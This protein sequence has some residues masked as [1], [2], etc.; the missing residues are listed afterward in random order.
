MGCLGTNH[1]RLLWIGF[2]V[3]VEV[4]GGTVDDE[5]DDRF[6]KLCLGFED[7]RRRGWGVQSVL[8][9]GVEGDNVSCLFQE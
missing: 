4:S 2:E 6:E 1:A 3:N 5:K 8:H 9:A 7:W